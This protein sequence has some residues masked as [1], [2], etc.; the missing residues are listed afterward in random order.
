MST[1][2]LVDLCREYEPWSVSKGKRSVQGRV[3]GI[4]LNLE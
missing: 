2:E 1:L 4:T 3:G